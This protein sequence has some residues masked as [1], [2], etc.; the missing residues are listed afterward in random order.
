MKIVFSGSRDYRFGSLEETN[1]N[2]LMDL[3]YSKYLN[4]D[5]HVGDCTGVDS[6]ILNWYNN[7]QLNNTIT[8]Y[9]ADK[10]K[11]SV[12]NGSKILCSDWK[13]DGLAAGPIRNKTMLS[14]NPD[15]VI[16]IHHS[17]NTSKGTLNMSKISKSIKIRLLFNPAT[18]I[19]ATI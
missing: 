8:I 1:I 3:L 14:C 11:F 15:M 17:L 12:Y 4:L 5:I 16:L 19:L 6:I 10:N 9:F 18:D 2:N 13:I 7:H